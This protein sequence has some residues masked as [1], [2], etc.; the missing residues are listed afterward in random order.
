[1]LF[2]EIV[3]RTI[4]SHGRAQAMKSCFGPDA[5]HTVIMSL[6]L[7]IYNATFCIS[8]LGT[9]ADSQKAVPFPLTLLIHNQSDDSLILASLPNRRHDDKHKLTSDKYVPVNED[10]KIYIDHEVDLC[11]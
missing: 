2:H 9:S 7:S 10:A 4:C 8:C 1:M 3:S 11:I 5:W 6:T